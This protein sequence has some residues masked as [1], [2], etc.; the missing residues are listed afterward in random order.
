MEREEERKEMK[1]CF[2]WLFRVEYY[3][4]IGT[5]SIKEW[6]KHSRFIISYFHWCW[7]IISAPWQHASPQLYWCP[8]TLIDVILFWY[9]TADMRKINNWWDV[10]QTAV[11]FS[12][13]LISTC[14]LRRVIIASLLSCVSGTASSLLFKTII[15]TTIHIWL[16][17]YL[18]IYICLSARAVLGSSLCLIDGENF[19]LSVQEVFGGYWGSFHFRRLQLLE[20][21]S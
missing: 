21:S 9:L 17:E 12:E 3:S 13:V 20:I 14:F 4:F 1:D 16:K 15:N 8:V 7:L 6:G 5:H 2:Y 19:S 11:I 10:F 18:M